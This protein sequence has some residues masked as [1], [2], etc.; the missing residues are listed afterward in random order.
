MITLTKTQ[1]STKCKIRAAITS[2]DLEM[3]K[4][5]IS[6][7]SF[8][9]ERNTTING[10]KFAEMINLYSDHSKTKAIA[11]TFINADEY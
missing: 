2:E 10:C 3:I 9:I 7:Y 1:T 5:G 11:D 4:Y 8:L 6:N